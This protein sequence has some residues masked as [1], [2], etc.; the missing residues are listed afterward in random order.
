M[1]WIASVTRADISDQIIVQLWD[2]ESGERRV[3][4]EDNLLP[5]VSLQ[6]QS[7]QFNADDTEVALALG[8]SDTSD[9]SRYQQALWRWSIETGEALSPH[10]IDCHPVIIDFAHGYVVCDGGAYF[11]Q[12]RSLSDGSPLTDP[13]FSECC[14]QT[15]VTTTDQ[16]IVLLVPWTEGFSIKPS[17]ST[18]T[19]WGIN[20]E[21]IATLDLGLVRIHHF[22]VS[23]D[24]TRIALLQ[25]NQVQIWDI[26]SFSHQLTLEH[27]GLL[28]IANL[29]ASPD[30]RYLITIGAYPD[31]VF[32]A[33]KYPTRTLRWD[34]Q[35]GSY[36]VIANQDRAF[37]A[38][39]SPDGRQLV[40]GR[41]DGILSIYDA[42]T[43][44]PQ[45]ELANGGLVAQVAF[46][47]DGHLLAVANEDYIRL[48]DTQTWTVINR[49]EAK[50]GFLNDRLL[51]A[52][53]DQW[54]VFNRQVWKIEESGRLVARW[55]PENANDEVRRL[56]SNGN[57]YTSH[58]Y[59]AADGL[60][61]SGLSLI[62]VN[63]GEQLWSDAFFSDQ[64]YEPKT[65][66]LTKDLIIAGGSDGSLRLYGI[67]PDGE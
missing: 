32:Y 25:Y 53:D 11:V 23:P 55:E 16:Y 51:F 22:A 44:T 66:A 35:A 15:K 39:Y 62:D 27:T 63:R 33:I 2:V 64:R 30:G 1:R 42:E 19:I 6:T 13:I 24:G 4:Y 45:N 18:V 10:S 9:S 5:E 49:V 67:V 31:P 7:V 50:S 36:E 60:L 57:D 41:N 28:N 8:Y 14:Y 38:A 29:A 3:L 43:L 34:L 48:W 37:A 26:A 58:S 20:G 59:R 54:L 46:S 61:V 65:V 21:Q 52:S 17:P 47:N 40:I 12:L 56:L